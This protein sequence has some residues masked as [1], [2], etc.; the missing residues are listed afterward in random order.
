MLAL[1]T[2]TTGWV[3]DWSTVGPAQPPRCSA[4]PHGPSSGQVYTL[5]VD[6]P[7]GP[8]D[9]CFATRHVAK[10]PPGPRPVLLYHHGAGGNANDCGKDGAVMTGEPLGAAVSRHGFIL[11]CTE[12]VQYAPHSSSWPLPGMGGGL[13]H[14]QD[15][16]TNATG[17]RCSEPYGPT[18]PG[19]DLRDIDYVHAVVAMLK[20]EPERYDMT[21]LFVH[22]C[23][24]GACFSSYSAQCLHETEG[25]SL[26][27]WS[28]TGS[29]LKSYGDGTELPGSPAQHPGEFFPFYPGA[30]AASPPLKAC[31][32]DN[33]DDQIGIAKG[34]PETSRELNRTWIERG[35]RAALTMHPTGGHCGIHD[36]EEVFECLDDGTGRLLG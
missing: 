7:D 10:L 32:F 9:R 33:L 34:I 20:Q 19:Y 36:W 12:A 24:M 17:N 5:K 23:S 1:A 18:P 6:S 35:N 27:A 22:G 15:N 28:V 14:L 2:L 25:A 29:G 11:V 8:Q 31:V 4:P 21:R 13:W 26:T 16:V 30:S 3:V